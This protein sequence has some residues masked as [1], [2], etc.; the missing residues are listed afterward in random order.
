MREYVWH[1]SGAVMGTHPLMLVPRTVPVEG[2]VH[3]AG[4]SAACSRSVAHSRGRR[5]PSN[6]GN[7]E[8][9]HLKRDIAG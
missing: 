3:N 9:Q 1:S 4:A 6:I 7:P 8:Q 2:Y 5:S